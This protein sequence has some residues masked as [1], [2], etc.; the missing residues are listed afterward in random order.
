MEQSFEPVSTEY[1]SARKLE[2]TSIRLR[3]VEN[4]TVNRQ[5]DRQTQINRQTE[6]KTRKTDKQEDKNKQRIGRTRRQTV[7][8]WT[9]KRTDKQSHSPHDDIPFF[10]KRKTDVIALVCPPMLLVSLPVSASHNLSMVSRLQTRPII[11][12]LSN[13]SLAET[14]NSEKRKISLTFYATLSFF[15]ENARIN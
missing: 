1:W 14:L 9:G 11:I 8:A 12:T 13:K 3:K 10:G 2:D 15:Q 4:S 6:S 5:T 7:C